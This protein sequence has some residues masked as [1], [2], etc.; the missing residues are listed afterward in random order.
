MGRGYG[1]WR[2]AFHSADEGYVVGY[3]LSLAREGAKWHPEDTLWHTGYVDF[4]AVTAGRDTY[5]AL[6][7]E[8]EYGGSVRG[9]YLYR[10]E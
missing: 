8:R 2:S 9:V 6:V 7:E 4:L 1:G 10:I 5:W 3:E